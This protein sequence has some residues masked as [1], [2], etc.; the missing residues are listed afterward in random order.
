MSASKMEHIT[1]IMVKNLKIRMRQKQTYIFSFGFPIIF[2]LMFYFMLGSEEIVSGFKIFT[3]SISGMLVYAASIGTINSAL[4]FSSEKQLG[5][6]IRLE[7]TP[8]TRTSI[9]IGS[10]FSEG[11]FMLIQS[12]I[13][14]I[15]GY[16][17]LGIKWGY[18]F[19]NSTFDQNISLI[20]L[21]FTI[22]FIFGLST[23]G[24]GIIISAYAKSMES[25]LGIANVYALPVLFLS[26]AMIPFESPIVYFF[27]P[28]WANQIY[29]QVVVLGH[30]LWTD[31]LLAN[32]S[33]IFTAP[34]T[35]L[36]LWSAFLILIAVFLITLI[37]GILMFNRKTSI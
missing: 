10:L 18:N 11:V 32:S 2:T 8:C 23:L 17:I 4:V 13:M 6:L 28:W 16:G 30:N 7:T 19:D 25:A 20:I 24:I 5:T 37:L 36:P 35:I 15:L 22:I 29:Q 14:F 3:L 34:A 31:P 1:A 12:I 9:F 27:P 26:G 21:G 33:N